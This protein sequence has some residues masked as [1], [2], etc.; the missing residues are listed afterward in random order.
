LVA[1]KARGAQFDGCLSQGKGD[2]FEAGEGSSERLTFRDPGAGFLDALFGGAD[3]HEADKGAA[4]I[5]P[6]HHLHEARPLRP[7]AR[8]QGNANGIEE[9]RA[10]A[11]GARAEVTK[12][13]ARYAGRVEID[14]EGADAARALFDRAGPGHYQRG[15][16]RRGERD[17]GFLAIEDIVIAFA[18]RLQLHMGRIGASAGLGYRESGDDF[19]AADGREKG[20]FL[21]LVAVSG[22]DGADQRG[23][24]KHVGGIEIAAR[25]LF[26][27]NSQG[28]VVQARA[29][30]L[31]IGHRGEH[32]QLTE[33]SDKRRR[34]VF[35]A[36]ARLI[37]RQEL[38]ARELAE[39]GLKE[40]L[41]GRKRKIHRRNL[42]LRCRGGGGLRARG[43]AGLLQL[44]ESPEV[45]VGRFDRLRAAGGGGGLPV[46]LGDSILDVVGGRVRGE[47]A[48]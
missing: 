13:G 15:C 48:P 2:A 22:D 34:Q 7:D 12:A 27:R 35:I 30:M 42:S 33:L 17:R 46:M 1:E 39:G 47:S 20:G 31:R 16:R 45:A 38:T 25:Y 26:V 29:A 6:L 3:A 32:A 28:Y 44:F 40:L 21:P 24:Q 11:D 43:Y 5:K 4:E 23:E 41:F 8:A 14:I 18:A 37:G 19:A 10:A 9:E 36:V